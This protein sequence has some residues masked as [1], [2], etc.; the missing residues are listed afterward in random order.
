MATDLDKL[1]SLPPS[2]RVKLRALSMYT[3]EQFMALFA[4]G[5]VG[6]EV[7]SMDVVTVAVK[8]GETLVDKPKPPLKKR[9]GGA[10]V[11][12]T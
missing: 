8:E 10:R 3:V 5:Q 7:V 6:P 4:P 12:K 1:T 11:P 2:A 9:G